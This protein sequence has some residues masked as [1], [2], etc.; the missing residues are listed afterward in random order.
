VELSDGSRLNSEAFMSHG[1]A[2]LLAAKTPM[3]AFDGG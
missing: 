3:V 1:N 2:S